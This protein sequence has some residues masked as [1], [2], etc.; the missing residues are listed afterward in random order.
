ML[1]S[2]RWMYCVLPP[3]AEAVAAKD[4]LGTLKPGNWLTSYCSTPT[5]LS[6]GRELVYVEESTL[7]AVAVSTDQGFILG[8][9]QRLFESED[10]LSATLPRNPM[11]PPAGKDF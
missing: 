9:P 5:R 1:G 11:Y 6:D 8:Q 7:M 10:L 2:S 4:D 3:P